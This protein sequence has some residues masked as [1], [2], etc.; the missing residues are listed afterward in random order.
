MGRGWMLYTGVHGVPG[1]LRMFKGE[2]VGAGV[3]SWVLGLLGDPPGGCSDG[4]PGIAVPGFPGAQAP[5][6]L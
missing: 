4:D 1:F 6:L 3:G 2:W 5:L